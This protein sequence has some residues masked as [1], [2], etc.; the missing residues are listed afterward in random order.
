MEK[1]RF[2]YIHVMNSG[3]HEKKHYHRQHACRCL[4]GYITMF[5][6][7]QHPHHHHHHHISSLSSSWKQ[8]IIFNHFFNHLVFPPVM[9]RSI[10]SSLTLSSLLFLGLTQRHLLQRQ[11]LLGGQEAQQGKKTHGPVAQILSFLLVDL[12]IHAVINSINIKV[13]SI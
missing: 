3:V 12:P 9:P 2:M 4:F 11:H 8:L 10:H 1:T 6:C 13:L 5:T 7:I